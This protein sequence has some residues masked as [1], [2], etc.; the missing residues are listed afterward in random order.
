ME[1][2][3][4]VIYG[5]EWYAGDHAAFAFKGIPCMVLSSSDLF[6]GALNNTHTMSDTADTID[7]NLI[8]PA[9]AYINSF[10]SEISKKELARR[11][12]MER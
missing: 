4:K 9:A 12:Q 11:K 3:K 1:E 5:S 10:V 8:E 2:R 7:L 6:D